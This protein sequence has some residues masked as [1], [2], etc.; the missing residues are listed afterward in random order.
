MVEFLCWLIAEIVENS[1]R[2]V[3][4][5]DTEDENRTMV[6]LCKL[7]P[8]S[9]RRKKYTDGDMVVLL[10]THLSITILKI[11]SLFQHRQKENQS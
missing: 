5:G 4:V 7:K 3:S 1:Y 8:K 10:C 9:A 2:A 11:L 6:T